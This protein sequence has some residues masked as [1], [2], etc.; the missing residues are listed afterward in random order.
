MEPSGEKKTDNNLTIS[1]VAMATFSFHSTQDKLFLCLL[2]VRLSMLS[3]SIYFVYLL[4][5]HIF[6][7]SLREQNQNQF[8]IILFVRERYHSISD[9]ISEKPLQDCAVLLNLCQP[10][11]ILICC[12]Y[13]HHHH[14]RYH[15]RYG[16][17]SHV[18]QG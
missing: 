11:F 18:I 3:C 14:H 15:R 10:F 8:W 17:T 5:V 1:C 2:N 9:I 16:I 12:H 7:I 4:I 6:P 13:H